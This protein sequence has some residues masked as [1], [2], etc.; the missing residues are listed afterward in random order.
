M[1]LDRIAFANLVRYIAGLRPEY[2]IDLYELDALI[3]IK[4]EPV[5]DIRVSVDAVNELLAA[6]NVEG[7]LI[8]AIRAYRSLTG[9]GLKEAKDAVEHYRNLKAIKPR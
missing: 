9:A 7:K 2:D 3:E 4:V 1:K 8:E 5:A 6:F